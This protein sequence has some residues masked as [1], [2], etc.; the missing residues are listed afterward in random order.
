MSKMKTFISIIL[1]TVGYRILGFLREITIASKFG[2]GIES[3]AYF[4]AYS[5]PNLI[6]EIFAVGAMSSAI[7]PIFMSEREDKEETKKSL[8]I[9]LGNITLL[10]M[11]FTI[12]LIFFI[13][14]IIE[15]LVPGFQIEAKTLTVS[16]SKVSI[17]ILPVLFFN[18]ILASF[19]NCYDKTSNISFSN[20]L[21]NLLFLIFSWILSYSYG[22]HGFVYSLLIAVFC[23]MVYSYI[24]LKTHIGSFGIRIDFKNDKFKKM[25]L[26]LTP[27]IISSIG[28]QINFIIDRIMA[29]QLKEGSISY[30]NYGNKI[31][32]L[33]LGILLGAAVLTGFPMLIEYIQENDSK[34]I[35]EYIW[36]KIELVLLIMGG[37]TIFLFL[38]S[39]WVVILLFQRGN[40]DVE[41]VFYL[42]NTLKCY[43]FSIVGISF[44]TLFQKIYHGMK[45][46][47]LPSMINLISIVLNIGLNLILTHYFKVFGIAIATSITNVINALILFVTIKLNYDFIKI[48]KLS[49]VKILMF[50]ILMGITFWFIKIYF[51]NYIQYN[52]L[53]KSVVFVLL[54]FLYVIPSILVLKKYYI[55]GKEI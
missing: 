6:I 42:S 12:V 31:I 49:L 5:L 28:V 8:Q 17:V 24:A 53:K 18:E 37:I 44:L 47:K 16:L 7:L 54:S 26:L 30:L 1:W 20:F 43:S 2:A 50:E 4:V 45:N 27:I 48:S 34:K 32:Q 35:K 9:L 23:K 11:I 29:S 36:E 51:S 15:K 14:D 21:Q 19:M 55:K 39:E 3:D 52:F 40:F 13:Q 41:A 38:F 22:I 46:T 33:P 25:L 10:S